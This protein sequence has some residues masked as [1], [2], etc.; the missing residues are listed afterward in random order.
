MWLAESCLNHYVSWAGIYESHA[1]SR[2]VS[3]DW[4]LS[5]NCDIHSVW[6][7]SFDSDAVSRVVSHAVDQAPSCAN[8]WFPLFP[9]SASK[10]DSI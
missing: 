6:T 4:W 5:Q 10:P 3:H 8:G 1:V 2:V 7:V 9:Y